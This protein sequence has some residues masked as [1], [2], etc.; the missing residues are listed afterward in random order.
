MGYAGL[1]SWVDS[2][3]A[4]DLTHSIFVKIEQTLKRELKEKDNEM[5][6]NGPINIALFFETFLCP[7][8]KD[9]YSYPGLCIVAK[10]TIDRL[11]NENITVAKDK[12]AGWDSEKNRI[13]HLEAYRRMKKNLKKFIEDAQ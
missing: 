13:D 10:D 9:L 5:N 7:I 11:E 1:K 3:N 2:D 4:A 12:T 8:A 6:T